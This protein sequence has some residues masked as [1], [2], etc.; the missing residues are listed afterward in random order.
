MNL[1]EP[2][3]GEDLSSVLGDGILADDG[4]RHGYGE[5][6]HSH[7]VA[8]STGNQPAESRVSLTLS[9]FTLV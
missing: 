9:L 3:Q 8:H 2:S 6:G 4:P 1:V 7:E 5:V